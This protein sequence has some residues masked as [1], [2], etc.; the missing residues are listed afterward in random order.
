[1]CPRRHHNIIF[2]VSRETT[3]LQLGNFGAAAAVKNCIVINSHEEIDDS[4]VPPCGCAYVK[5]A[6]NERRRAASPVYPFSK[7]LYA[8]KCYFFPPPPTPPTTTSRD[9][10]SA[11][12]VAAVPRP[13]VVGRSYSLSFVLSDYLF[14]LFFC[15][16]VRILLYY[17]AATV[18]HIIII[19]ICSRVVFTEL[20]RFQS[21][22]EKKFR[23]SANDLNNIMR[24]SGSA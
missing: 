20:D 8:T 9:S 17:T 13:A 7:L 12:A 15:L 19:I 24:P 2:G 14:I 21:E 16:N 22:W 6:V 23:G 10:P 3:K 11:T 18:L 5:F 4:A 1:M